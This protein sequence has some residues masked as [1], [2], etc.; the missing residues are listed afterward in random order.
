[1]E[2]QTR[3]RGRPTKTPDRIRSARVI[4]QLLPAELDTVIATA[5]ERRLSR[6]D[7]LRAGLRAIGVELLDEHYRVPP[8]D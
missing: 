7:L 5:R 3:G 1:M 2:N 6:S 4:A 8:T